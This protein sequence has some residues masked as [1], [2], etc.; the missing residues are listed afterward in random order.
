MQTADVCEISA[1]VN[2]GHISVS[3]KCLR[4]SIQGDMDAARALKSMS[5]FPVELGEQKKA[6]ISHSYYIF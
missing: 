4:V 3:D 2:S 5:M 1:I 6:F